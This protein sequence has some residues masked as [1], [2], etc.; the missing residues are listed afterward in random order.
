[1]T[2]ALSWNGGTYQARAAKAASEREREPADHALRPGGDPEADVERRVAIAVALSLLDGLHAKGA[3]VVREQ[4]PADGRHDDAGRDGR[5]G[6]EAEPLAIVA[7]V[8]F[9]RR[10]ERKTTE[11]RDTRE[12]NHGS[13]DAEDEPRGGRTRAGVADVDR[14]R[15]PDVHALRAER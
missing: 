15:A 14:H 2:T 9:A 6:V 1:M 12:E 10:L 8:R 5:E 3:A 4:A 11:R 13:R 7:V